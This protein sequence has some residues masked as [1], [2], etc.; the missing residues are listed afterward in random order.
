[1]N[2]AA[3]VRLMNERL[4]PSTAFTD[5]AAENSGI[6]VDIRQIWSTIYRNKYLIALIVALVLVAG[7]AVTLLSTPVYKADASVQVEQQTAKV[8]STEDQEPMMSAQEGDRFLQTQL[9]ILKSRAIAIRV[10]QSL[11]LLNSRTFL[12]RMHVKPLDRPLGDL[13]MPASRREQIIQLL[14]LKETVN[15]PRNSRVISVSFL[16]PDPVLAAQIANSFVQNFITSNL[17]RRFD[18][19]SYSRDFL[20]RQLAE[21]KRRL[22]DSERAMIGY[23]RAAHLIDTSAGS[24]DGVNM[25]PRSLTTADLVQLNVQL[26]QAKAQTVDTQQRYQQAMRTPLMS[27]P[28]VLSN[29]AIQQLAQQQALA[30]AAYD[31]EKQRH[32]ANYPTMLQSAALIQSLNEQVRMLATSIRNGIRDQ[33]QTALHQQQALAGNVSGLEGATLAE[34]DRS[35]QYNILRRETDTNR[36]MYDGLLQRFKEV[37]AAAGVTANNISVVDTADTPSKP[38][39]PRPLINLAL[40]LILGTAL[41]AAIVFLREKFYDVIRSPED[42][43]RKLGLPFLNSVPL[44]PPNVTPAEALASPRSPMS[45]SYAALRTS[46]ELVSSTGLSRSVLFTSSRQSEGKSTTAYAV[47]RDFARIGKRVLLVDGDLRKP[48]LHRQLLLI[49]NAGFASLLARQRTFD[50]VVQQTDTP[51]LDFLSCGP[52]PP[53]PAELLSGAMLPEQMRQLSEQYD[54]IIVDG[55]P[56]LGLADAVLLATNVEGTVFVVEANG[57]HNGHAKAAVRRLTTSGVH[58]LGAVLTKFDARKIGYGDYYGYYG[59]SYGQ[60]VTTAHG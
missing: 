6:D 41:A 21:A 3:P 45:E 16:S 1:M 48:S 13:S 22:E 29:P 52:L 30:Q 33:Y 59:Y 51:N 28:E 20:A 38:V 5:P 47:A 26:N 2:T 25:G 4:M 8:L 10:M 35:V 56:V 58:L 12:D 60:D 54:L 32:E 37:S 15:L 18:T 23:A 39:S 34:Q 9:D 53:N 40:S 24:T 42:I 14:L 50:Q 57:S 49:N 7:I 11:D 55:P 19:S 27:L 36:T 43:A 46:L 17:Q 44:L 31:Q